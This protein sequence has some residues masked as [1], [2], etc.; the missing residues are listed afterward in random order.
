MHIRFNRNEDSSVS[1]QYFSS[2][3]PKTEESSSIYV[4]TGNPSITGSFLIGSSLR[5]WG[6]HT[7]ASLYFFS[8]T[9][10]NCVYFLSLALKIV[11]CG[12]VSFDFFFF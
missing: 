8:K 11:F 5:T 12:F 10:F 2:T 4:C 1:E 7:Q 6:I 3:T 9:Q